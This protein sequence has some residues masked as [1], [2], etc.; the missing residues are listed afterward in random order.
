MPWESWKAGAVEAVV[1]AASAATRLRMAPAVGDASYWLRI[2]STVGPRPPNPL[3]PWAW[4]GS[5]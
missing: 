4:I 1:E 3:G 5:S 2:G